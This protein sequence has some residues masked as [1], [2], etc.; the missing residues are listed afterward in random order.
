MKHYNDI[1]ADQLQTVADLLADHW[2]RCALARFGNHHPCKD[3]RD[4]RAVSW[5]LLGAMEK[6]E[7]DQEAVIVV[8]RLA[9][10]R[11]MSPTDRAAIMYINDRRGKGAIL[12]LLN[13][14]IDELRTVKMNCV[15]K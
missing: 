14:A 6:L 2:T 12:E 5:C 13:D 7:V 4:D 15:S 1:L 9:N 10:Q 3:A 8:K 11:C